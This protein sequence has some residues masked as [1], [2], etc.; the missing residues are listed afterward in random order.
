MIK[1]ILKSLAY[2]VLDQELRENWI[3]RA[4]FNDYTQWMSRDFP[5]M[6]DMHKQF[7]NR[8]Y[9]GPIECARHR[10]EMAKK[11]KIAQKTP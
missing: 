4:Y 5:I 3:H 11:Y 9:G 10:D 7:E 8:H 1:G 2:R 6:N